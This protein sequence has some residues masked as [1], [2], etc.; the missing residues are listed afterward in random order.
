MDILT[1]DSKFK[2]LDEIQTI[3]PS[4]ITWP[5]E[6][7]KPLSK[8]SVIQLYSTHYT[9]L[10]KRHDALTIYGQI[11]YWPKS[12]CSYFYKLLNFSH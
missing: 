6:H 10:S 9:K 3:E 7:F 1:I 2:N 12:G 8:D 11:V 5:Y 4:P